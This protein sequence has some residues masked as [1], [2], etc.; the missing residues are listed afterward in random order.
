[1]NFKISFWNLEICGDILVAS[2]D[3]W[4]FWVNN[5]HAVS[6]WFFPRPLEFGTQVKSLL[7][8]GLIFSGKFQGEN[9]DFGI[10]RT[11]AKILTYILFCK[12]GK[13]T[14]FLYISIS[15]CAKCRRKKQTCLRSFWRFNVVIF[16][17]WLAKYLTFK[18]MRGVL[19]ALPC[20][21]PGSSTCCS[22]D[23]G[24]ASPSLCSSSCEWREDV[25]T[26]HMRLHGQP[27]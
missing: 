9:K 23:C 3:V 18:G 20:L 15:S 1:M 21:P 16:M 24:L 25:E 10:R 27:R 26:W 17:K 8:P 22:V 4:E 2:Q 14:W 5:Q 12:L 19:L 11:Q 6:I 13:V 7:S